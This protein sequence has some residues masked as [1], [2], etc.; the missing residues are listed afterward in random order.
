MKKLN[1]KILGL[2]S[3]LALLSTSAPAEAASVSPM[4]LIGG[5]TEAAL[6][7]GG[8]N[9][10]LRVEAGVGTGGNPCKFSDAICLRRLTQLVIMNIE[11][12]VAIDRGASGVDA[13]PRMKVRFTPISIPGYTQHSIETTDFS[14]Y[15]YDSNIHFSPLRTEIT[16]DVAL[17]NKLG[18]RITTIAIDGKFQS[19]PTENFGIFTQFA[20][21]ALA[22]R[23]MDFQYKDGNT[24]TND[25]LSLGRVGVAAGFIFAPSES[26]VVRLTTGASIEYS[27][28]GTNNRSD[29]RET[30]LYAELRVS[31]TRLVDVFGRAAYRI[32]ERERDAND[33]SYVHVSTGIEV[34]LDWL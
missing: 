32:L 29:L 16:R 28:F 18:L 19:F 1:S 20:A 5:G 22:Y 14:K 21:D 15:G 25:G 8:A 17:G 11:G 2:V 27:L 24:V 9:M 4:I 12:E 13:Y 23:Y 31:I 33:V 6:G 10:L 7:Q 26:F 34:K 30:E 3:V